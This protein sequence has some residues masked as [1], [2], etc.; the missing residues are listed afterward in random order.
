MKIILLS[1]LHGTLRKPIARLDKNYGGT[2]F[3]KLHYVF[4]YAQ[5]NHIDTIL[6]AGDMCDRPREWRFLPLI[7]RL[8]KAFRGITIFTVFGQH[9]SYLRSKESKLSTT[10][11]IL[12][13]MD[14]VKILSSVPTVLHPEVKAYG[15]SY[16]EPIPEPVLN[17][18]LNIL[19]CHHPIVDKVSDF[20]HVAESTSASSFLRTANKTQK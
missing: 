4:K 19:V 5:D 6:Q 7:I 9:D 8:L 18:E 15:A 2:F 20:P 13:E 11:G 16:N 10:L 12:N 1:D 3:K 17:K 14:L